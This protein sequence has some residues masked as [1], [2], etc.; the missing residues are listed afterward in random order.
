MKRVFFGLISLILVLEPFTRAVASEDFYANPAYLVSD[1]E[2]LDIYS[3]SLTDVER[4][5]MRGGLASYVG[6]DVHGVQRSAAEII[7]NAALEFDL[8]PRFLL[9]LLQREQSLVEDD[10]P[11]ERQLDWAMGYA[12]CDSCSKEDPR[13]QKFKGFGN[14]VHY[15][16][17]RIRESYLED[18][19]YRGYTETGMG[20]GIE[21]T[22]D[23]TF[24]TPVNNATAA[25]YTYTPHL[26]GNEN[27]ARI[28][29][30]WFTYQYVSG[31][32]LQNKEDGGIWLIQHGERRPITSQTAFYSRFNPDTVVQVSISTLENYP[33][34][35]PISFPNYSLLRAPTGTI[36]L[37]VDD[38]RRGFTSA[39]AFRSL[40]FSTDEVVDVTWEDLEAYTD[41]EPLTVASTYTQGALLQD[42]TTGGI[43]YVND[44]QKHPIYSREVL[45]NRF[46]DA[47]ITPVTPED[48]NVFERSTPVLF[49]DGTLIAVPGSPD[50]FVVS[51]GMRRHIGDE[52]TFY[53]FGWD[54]SQVVWTS[55]RAVLEHP[56]GEPL[57]VE[58]DFDTADVEIAHF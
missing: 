24:V 15:A 54:W 32:L 2:M 42:N 7:Y 41:G 35:A 13:I 38:T 53:T 47:V 17:A 52:L 33:I 6:P 27:F 36:Y 57:F 43:F 37:I 1:A 44:T 56:L 4:F 48:L 10:S 39:E 26:H 19:D 8:S 28:W 12:V 21:V 5:L 16:A 46:A 22:I 51:E 31:S 55:E 20:P 25:L 23:G 29:D 34:G 50:V 3:M 49:Q 9:V 18:L 11:S 40:G 45:T 30:R 58:T 14:Q